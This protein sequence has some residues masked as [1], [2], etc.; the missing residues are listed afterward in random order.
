MRLDDAVGD[1][2][3]S[4]GRINVC[5]CPIDQV[6]QFSA[7]KVIPYLRQKNYLLVYFFLT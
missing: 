6:R 2:L 1:L 3:T 5:V 7:E 4:W